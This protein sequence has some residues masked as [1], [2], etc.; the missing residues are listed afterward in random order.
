MAIQMSA[1]TRPSQ[2]LDTTTTPFTQASSQSPSTTADTTS[3]RDTLSK[4]ALAGFIVLGCLLALAFIWCFQWVSNARWKR[5][6]RKHLME[7][8]QRRLE[9][10]VYP[11]R[12]GMRRQK[13]IWPISS[14]K[15]T[16]ETFLSRYVNLMEIISIGMSDSCS[17]I[18]SWVTSSPLTSSGT[19]FRRSNRPPCR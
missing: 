14:F 3:P 11:W 8:R 4:G 18:V 1:S 15:S 5:R 12:I 16:S 10:E 6:W 7:Q 19:F 17:S 9:Y 2:P 13:E